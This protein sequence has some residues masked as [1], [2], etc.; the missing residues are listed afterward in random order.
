MAFLGSWC[1]VELPAQPAKDVKAAPQ[2]WTL[3][4]LDLDHPRFAAEAVL[5]CRPGPRGP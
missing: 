2:T 3:E 5:A 1:E 4:E